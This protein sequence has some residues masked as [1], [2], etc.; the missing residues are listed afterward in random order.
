M[1]KKALFSTLGV[2]LATIV[3][4]VALVFTVGPMVS[5]DEYI[6]GIGV[7]DKV[8][9][10]I[11]DENNV[12]TGFSEK[13]IEYAALFDKVHLIYPENISG[14]C[15]DNPYFYIENI[16]SIYVPSGVSYDDIDFWCSFYIYSN[17]EL[18]RIYWGMTEADFHCSGEVHSWD[19]VYGYD[20]SIWDND[21]MHDCGQQFLFVFGCDIDSNG[22]VFNKI[23]DATCQIVG[24]MGNKNTI[25]LPTSK[26]NKSVVSIHANAFEDCE[27]TSVHIPANI[28]EIGANVFANNLNEI[29]V[30]NY[31]LMNNVNLVPYAS[32]LSYTAPQDTNN[33]NQNNEHEQNEEVTT[34]N[35]INNENKGGVVAA[36]AGTAGGAAGLGT[37]GTIFGIVVSRKRKKL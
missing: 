29:I 13:G 37:M 1:N 19:I 5:A 25:T 9:Y 18:V 10:Y 30:E 6:G 2:M 27:F 14:I 35:S 4:A 20:Y 15:M 3:A 24:Y 12:L 21:N 23:D 28:T 8:E 22:F 26:G 36:V 32:I 11:V 31:E 17:Q 33:E 16:A 7:L 34:E